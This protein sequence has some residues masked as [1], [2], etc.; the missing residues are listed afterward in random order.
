MTKDAQGTI[1]VS[2][3]EGLWRFEP[4]H[5]TME[6]IQFWDANNKA[7]GVRI[8]S[9]VEVD[10]TLWGV[11]RTLGLFRLDPSRENAHLIHLP[12][13]KSQSQ[14]CRF[15]PQ[16][17]L[18]D[19]DSNQLGKLLVSSMWG[20]I[21]RIDP[22]T[23]ASE[24]LVTGIN[25]GEDGGFIN[26]YLSR[27]ATDE[28]GNLWFDERPGVISVLH[29]DSEKIHSYQLEEPLN[30]Y[31]ILYMGEQKFLLLTNY[32]G[33]YIWTPDKGIIEQ[34]TV[35][36]DHPKAL[37]SGFIMS[38]YY[39]NYKKLWLGT[40]DA[41]VF[42]QNKTAQKI[43][44]HHR[45][46]TGNKTIAG[47]YIDNLSYNII[48]GLNW[49]QVTSVANN[50]TIEVPTDFLTN[51]IVKVNESR[52]ILGTSTGLRQL[53]ISH[54][55]GTLKGNVTT[56]LEHENIFDV[57]LIGDKLFLGTTSGIKVS[58]LQQPAL[59]RSIASRDIDPSVFR[60]QV[61][62]MDYDGTWLWVGSHRNN[63]LKVAPDTETIEQHFTI[64]NQSDDGGWMINLRNLSAS[65]LVVTHGVLGLVII[66][67][68][69]GSY[70]VYGEDA[71]IYANKAEAIEV[72]DDN[73]IWLT[74]AY[75]LLKFDI[76]Q[77]RVQRTLRS[78][79]GTQG[80]T[81]SDVSSFKIG[82]Q[83]FAFG[84]ENGVTEFCDYDI[85]QTAKLR[86]PL[87]TDLLVNL[88]HLRFEEYQHITNGVSIRD[89]DEL[90]L[91][92]DENELGLYF[93]HL[94]ADDLTQVQY[95]TPLHGKDWITI[96]DKSELVILQRIPKGSHHF[97][98]RTRHPMTGQTSDVNQLVIHVAP[99]IWHTNI[100]YLLYA[101]LGFV[102]LWAGIE[103]RTKKHRQAAI[104][105]ASEVNKQTEEI[106]HK[107]QEIEQQRKQLAKTLE[108]KTL[109]FEQ[110]SHE[111]RTPL[112][113][114]VTPL[115]HIKSLLPKSEGA[116]LSSMA[117]NVN[118]LES[119]VNQLLHISRS[120][121][122]VQRNWQALPLKSWISD[123]L[124]SH[125]VQF[126][127]SALEVSLQCPDDLVVNIVPEGCRTD[128]S[129]PD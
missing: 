99:A 72:I 77:G 1:W 34:L 98:I 100:A 17:T 47:I 27:I 43:A 25:R 45:Q 30:I 60:S 89:A 111:L 26:P 48:S 103:W 119:M 38:A 15:C 117:A 104:T 88:K 124:R 58:T 23:L 33:A 70:Q 18:L 128:F 64:N 31:D 50:R 71:G 108:E 4:A 122:N 92:A 82:H 46:Q 125:S 11:S 85:P 90:W 24:P 39:D 120:K 93:S 22:E 110:I 36:T 2:S 123:L 16:N 69:D 10:G 59:L 53:D 54:V 113:L 51:V 116:L 14:D 35:S 63:I 40:L 49:L 118:R 96:L 94:N 84:G 13:I 56:L 41:G 101:V 95:L 67:K 62:E 74:G 114:L 32:R 106:R 21:Y 127:Q 19:I 37:A 97:S 80:D 68:L 112:S 83:C 61:F 79:D 6:K 87:F 66:N 121:S 81:Y 12:D 102:L 9:V 52:F 7:E 129:K 57:E 115:T 75:G 109:L 42:R 3:D 65:H 78:T 29:Q 73:T 5:Q 76:K 20:D 28:Q 105:L 107:N 86:T 8:R 44:F 55:G 91:K 126:Q